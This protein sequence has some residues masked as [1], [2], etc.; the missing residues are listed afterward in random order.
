MVIRHNAVAVPRVTG[1][2]FDGGAAFDIVSRQPES[3]ADVYLWRELAF[4]CVTVSATHRRFSLA[5]ARPHAFAS[6]L[7]P[8]AIAD[9]SAVSSATKRMHDI[10][11]PP[12]EN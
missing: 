6:S 1:V 10:I 4:A 5:E 7:V 12:A 8:S 9:P 2:V 11:G 3:E